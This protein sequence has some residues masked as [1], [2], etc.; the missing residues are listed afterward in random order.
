VLL[1]FLL[2]ACGGKGNDTALEDL[3]QDGYGAGWDCDDDDAGVNPG[4]TETPYDGVD[5]DCDA[6]TLDDD[7]DLDGY[8]AEED[9]DDENPWAYPGSSEV[10]DGA[11][12]DCDGLVDDDALDTLAWYADSDGDDYGD[13]EVQ[14]LACTQPSGYVADNTDCDDTRDDVYP[15]AEE[16]YDDV[17]NDCDGVVDEEGGGPKYDWYHDGDSDGYGDPYDGLIQTEQPYG[18]VANDGDCDDDDA[19]IHPGATESCDQ[20]DQDCDGQTDEDDCCLEQDAGLAVDYWTG[21]SSGDAAGSALA[22]G[23][24]LTDDGYDDFMVGAPGTSNGGTAYAMAGGFVGY[25]T[26]SDLDTASAS[27]GISWSSVN[28]GAELG[29]HLAMF[30]D[31]DGDGVGDFALGAPGADGEGTGSGLIV[32]WASADSNYYYVTSNAYEAALGPVASGGDTDG[33]GLSDM[34]LG[35]SRYSNGQWQQGFAELL[36]GDSSELVVLAAMWEGESAGDLVGSNLASAGDIDG[37][38][39]QDSLIAGEGYSA[40][41]DN[42]AIWIFMGSRFWPEDVLPL[43]D[44]NHLLVGEA[45]GDLAGAAMAGGG[46][47]DSDGYGDFLVGAPKQD[48]ADVDAGSVY[49]W[50][51]GSGWGSD[52]SSTL[53]SAADADFSGTLSG[54]EA[55]SS[56]ALLEDFDSDGFADLAAGAPDNRVNGIDAGKAYLLFGGPGRW[57]GSHS[58]SEADVSWLGE[59]AYDGLGTAVSTAG[60]VDADGATDLVLGAPGND[61]NGSGAGKVYL[62]LGWG[63]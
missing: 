17:D 37:D 14:V 24:D 8:G 6:S 51:G 11:D 30:D 40:G 61:D 63:P 28:S 47:V 23:V 7:L 19:E 16:L 41:S 18:Y 31:L 39:L 13:A 15:H 5:N 54:E 36:H 21:D 9:C 32:T 58:L 45:G 25:D 2:A 60:D 44:A 3:D 42:G 49:L 48:S 12:N 4:Q 35:A 59:A 20:V 38:G 50:M 10:C 53:M 29:A 52:S 26:G 43:S 33:D 62:I 22:G 56:V 1:L 55:G 34:L 57:L 27:G 46:D